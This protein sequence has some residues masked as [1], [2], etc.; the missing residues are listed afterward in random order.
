MWP[1]PAWSLGLEPNS[2][3][4]M[5]QTIST[6]GELCF[7]WVLGMVWGVS[8]RR[9]PSCLGSRE[10]LHRGYD[11]PVKWWR[12]LMALVQRSLVS[13]RVGGPWP[14]GIQVSGWSLT[15]PREGRGLCE[16]QCLLPRQLFF[17][18]SF[19]RYEFLTRRF[20]TL[21]LFNATEK[22]FQKIGTF[23]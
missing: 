16:D 14:R 7:E 11:N 5:A 13:G 10:V 15:S 17:T 18:F 23:K 6:E 9:C 19:W 21:K 4:D 20:L 22:S 1:S 3:V 12:W 8:R 2:W